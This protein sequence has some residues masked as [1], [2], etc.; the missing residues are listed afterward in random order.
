[1]AVSVCA[2]VATLVV[3]VTNADNRLEP[4]V[5]AVVAAFLAVGLTMLGARRLL[6]AAATVAALAAAVALPATSLSSH[7]TAVDAALALGLTGL[8][9]LVLTRWGG[10]PFLAPLVVT[11]LSA[12]LAARLVAGIGPPAFVPASASLRH[13]ALLGALV[14][15]GL[16][17]LALRRSSL[18]LALVAARSSE[19]AAA[20]RGVDVA[21]VRW[22]AWVI[23]CLLAAAGGCALALIPGGA[24]A[25]PVDSPL[26]ELV[27][28][29]TVLALALAAEARRRT[30]KTPHAAVGP[31]ATGAVG[32]V[33]SSRTQ[34]TRFGAMSGDAGPGAP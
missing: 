8:G 9:V 32:T 1:M 12:R 18:R 15:C 24:A 29:T 22:T 11:A 30:H 31:A 3:P 26:V 19:R 16:G 21:A 17:V 20:L 4:V 33:T 2:V 5:L 6:A 25:L 23:G 27:V 10:Q 34:G 28:G 14:L 13:E 7:L